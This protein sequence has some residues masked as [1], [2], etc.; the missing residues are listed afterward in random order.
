MLFLSLLLV[1]VVVR[2]NHTYLQVHCTLIPEKKKK[3]NFRERFHCLFDLKMSSLI[4]TFHNR[5]PLIKGPDKMW[6]QHTQRIK[7]SHENGHPTTLLYFWSYII[8]I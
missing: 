3:K 8:K 4:S 6:A 1:V 5:M 2:V 7:V